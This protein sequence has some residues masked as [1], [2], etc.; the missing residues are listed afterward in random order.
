MHDNFKVKMFFKNHSS[1]NNRVLEDGF[2]LTNSIYLLVSCS[3]LF[4]YT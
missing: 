2:V 4:D 3:N 1:I